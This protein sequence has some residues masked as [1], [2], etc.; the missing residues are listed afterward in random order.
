MGNFKRNIDI[1]GRTTPPKMKTSV[2]IATRCGGLSAVYLG[3]KDKQRDFGGFGRVFSRP[4]QRLIYVV[5]QNQREVDIL[6]RATGRSCQRSATARGSSSRANSLMLFVPPWIPKAMYMLPK[7]KAVGFKD[8]KL[9]VRNTVRHAEALKSP[10][11]QAG[12][13]RRRYQSPCGGG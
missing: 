3:A 7:T 6:D 1:R 11:D 4:N 13:Y 9:S 12:E 5:N 8:S 10:P 2:S